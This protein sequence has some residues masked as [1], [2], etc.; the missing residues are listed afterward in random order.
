MLLRG[1]T[2]AC[3][4]GPPKKEQHLSIWGTTEGRV[5]LKQSGRRGLEIQTGESGTHGWRMHVKMGRQNA[6]HC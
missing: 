5:G 2:V 6:D 1:E 4:S 3:R